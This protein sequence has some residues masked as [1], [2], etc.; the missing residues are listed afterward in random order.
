VRYS[1]LFR[2]PGRWSFTAVITANTE[3]TSSQSNAEAKKNFTGLATLASTREMRGEPVSA[4]RA[5]GRPCP[6]GRLG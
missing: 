1:Q 4:G 5:C 6:G 2:N 3:E